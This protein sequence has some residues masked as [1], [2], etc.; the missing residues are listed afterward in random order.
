MINNGEYS[1]ILADMK[2]RLAKWHQKTSDF[3]T[4]DMIKGK[5]LRLPKNK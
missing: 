2:T 3:V 1:R 4:R 5:W